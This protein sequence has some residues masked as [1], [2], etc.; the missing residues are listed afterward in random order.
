MSFGMVVG[1]ILVWVS[2]LVMMAGG[3]MTLVLAFRVSVRWGLLVLFV[4]FANVYVLFRFWPDTKRAVQVSL[5]GL[6]GLVV[7]IIV[8]MTSA[9]IT[10]MRQGAAARAAAEARPT[11]EAAWVPAIP[12]SVPTPTPLPELPIGIPEETPAPTPSRPLPLSQADEHLGRMVELVMRDGS[13]SRVI[14]HEVT[15]THVRVAEP[16]G[17]GG[18]TYSVPLARVAGFRPLRSRSAA[19]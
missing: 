17:G 1:M 15:A 12:Q 14:L 3:I 8:L 11:P 16:Y 4:P 2:S 18:I 5:A 13:T 19:R 7:G 9:A 6:G 10:G